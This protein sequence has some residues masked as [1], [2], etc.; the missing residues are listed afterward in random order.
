MKG[1]NVVKKDKKAK[2]QQDIEDMM[3][4][5]EPIE[6]KQD[7]KL[8]KQQKKEAK[9]LAKEQQEQEKIQIQLD[10]LAQDAEE[11]H[12][13]VEKREAWV[14]QYFKKQFGKPNPIYLNLIQIDY[15]TVI[16]NAKKL[17]GLKDGD[18]D[19]YHYVIAPDSLDNQRKVRYRFDKQQ[20]KN[21]QLYYDQVF[22]N[23]I[24]FGKDNMYIY[25]ANIDHATGQIVQETANEFSYF[26]VVSIETTRKT[27]QIINPKYMMVNLNLNLSDSEEYN[28]NL[29]NQRLYASQSQNYIYLILSIIISI[30]A[31][32]VLGIVWKY[33]L[34]GSFAFALVIAGG[35]IEIFRHK[36]KIGI[37]CPYLTE[38]EE[39]IINLIKERI[40]SSKENKD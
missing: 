29:R 3:D 23:V 12:S 32:L 27:D 1:G 15:Q 17:L 34:Y 37:D 25:R 9:R 10:E 24:F 26:D 40:R 6:E 33:W 18:Y 7:R 13:N 35:V 38:H 14:K 22:M 8:A 4:D 20:D 31:F 28:V 19:Q 30:A 39:M 16:E 2:K 11:L 36:H 21:Y 5:V